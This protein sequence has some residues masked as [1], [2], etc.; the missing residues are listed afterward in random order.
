MGINKIKLKQIDADFSGLVGQYGSGYFA[1]AGSLSA[2]SGSAVPYSYIATGGFVYNI[3]AQSVS[4]VK[5]FFSRPTLSGKSLAK[6]EEVVTISSN[7]TIYGQ[8]TFTAG[9]DTTFDANAVAFQYGTVD[10]TDTTFVFDTNSSAS[11]VTNLSSNIVNTTSNQTVA[12]IKNFSAGV[13]RVN[14]TGVLLS[15]Q[16]NPIYVSGGASSTTR[17]PVFVEDSVNG[18]KMAQLNTG[19]SYYPATNMLKCGSFSGSLI[20]NSDGSTASSG[21]YTNGNTQGGPMYLTFVNQTGSGVRTLNVNSGLSYSTSNGGVLNCGTFAASNSA[22]LSISTLASADFINFQFPTSTTAYRMTSS[23][24]CSLSNG[25][26]ALGQSSTPWSAVF[27][28]TSTIQTSDRNL[29]TEISEIPDSWLDAWQDVDYFRYKFK[30]AV[31]QKGLSGAR[32]HIGHIA[33]DIHE[34]F[35]NRGLNAFDIGMLC[36]DK[37]DQSID[38]NGNVVPSGEIWAIRPDECQFMEMALMRRS[39]NRLKSGILI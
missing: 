13:L 10:F 3:G 16:V 7:E 25:T 31:A 18:F 19:L 17:F 29:K 1:T 6:L 5:N 14:G 34:K 26:R 35:L 9:A 22:G 4:G 38:E 11:L 20:G 23:Y 30:D 21:V 27:A 2:L 37:W 36:Y 8:K 28:A 12:G 24:F 32:W 39:L 15:G 33:Q